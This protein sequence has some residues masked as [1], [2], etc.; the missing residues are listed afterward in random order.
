MG[1]F[2]GDKDNDLLPKGSKKH[3]SA[4]MQTQRFKQYM[5]T[6]ELHVS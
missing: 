1:S 6:F 4:N 5:K 2:D 3:S